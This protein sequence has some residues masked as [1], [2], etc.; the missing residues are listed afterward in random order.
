MNGESQERER[1][2]ERERYSVREKKRVRA[3][4]REREREREIAF[5][6]PN[7]PQLADTA[8]LGCSSAQLSICHPF[9][10]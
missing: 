8:V 7:N 3:R 10:R 1:E 9:N 5:I 6:A 4:E 2:K